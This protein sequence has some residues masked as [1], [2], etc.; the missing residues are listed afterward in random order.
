MLRKKTM[1]EILLITKS[2]KE[3]KVP[4]EYQMANIPNSLT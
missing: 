3:I 2:N 1:S 4:E